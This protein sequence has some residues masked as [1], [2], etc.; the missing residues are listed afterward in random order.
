M[1]IELDKPYYKLDRTKKYN[2]KGFSEGVLRFLESDSKGLIITQA[3]TYTFILIEPTD[4]TERVK[5]YG[6]MRMLNYLA[7]IGK[8]LSLKEVEDLQESEDVYMSV[9][10]QLM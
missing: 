1:N 5:T 4:I 8:L 7:S 9:T 3:N 6:N 10:L 2:I